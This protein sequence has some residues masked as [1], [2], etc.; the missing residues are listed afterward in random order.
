MNERRLI[1]RAMIAFYAGAIGLSAAGLPVAATAA[2]T[3]AAA[4]TS[5]LVKSP[6]SE[7]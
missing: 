3:A 1:I 2:T 5:I 7:P 4:L 6:N